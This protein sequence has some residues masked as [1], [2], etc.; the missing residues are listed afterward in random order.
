MPEEFVHLGIEIGRRSLRGLKGPHAVP[1]EADRAT[2]ADL[3]PTRVRQRRNGPE[4]G[5]DLVSEQ[6]LAR[7]TK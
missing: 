4:Q 3:V 7:D 6:L 2:G 5:T 1:R